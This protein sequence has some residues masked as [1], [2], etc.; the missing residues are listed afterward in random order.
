[1]LRRP[2][3]RKPAFVANWLNQCYREDGTGVKSGFADG[4]TLI[5]SQ[6]DLLL[7]DD[8][9]ADHTSSETAG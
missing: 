9:D 6:L 1:M 5:V 4:V 8:I 3:W 7:V 2:H